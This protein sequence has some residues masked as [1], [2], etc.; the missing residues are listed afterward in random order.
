M[1]K[2]TEKKA[3]NNEDVREFIDAVKR[4]TASINEG[5][6]KT[7]ALAR[8][9]D[10][11][12]LEKPDDYHEKCKLIQGYYKKDD[13]FG[14]LVDS[15][16]EF[17]ANGHDW[18]VP[19][20]QRGDMKKGGEK[21][22]LEAERQEAVWRSWDRVIN[23]DINLMPGT[24]T[25]DDWIM[26]KA[27]LT[28]MCALT[29][30]YGMVKTNKADDRHRAYKMPRIMVNWPSESV[31]LVRPDNWEVPEKLYLKEPGTD[32]KTVTESTD[33]EEANT[34]DP[35]P[36]LSDYR[37]QKSIGDRDETYGSFVI[38]YKWS[39]ADVTI[40]DG[41]GEFDTYKGLYP[42]PPYE[43]L[44]PWLMMREAMCSSDLAILDG[45]INLLLVWWIGSEKYDPMAKT[46]A[47]DG[48]V[49]RESDFDLAKQLLE[50]QDVK[51]VMELFLPHYIKPEFITPPT[52]TMTDAEKYIQATKEMLQFFGIFEEDRTFFEQIIKSF[53]AKILVP[54]WSL[55]T[56]DIVDRNE[57]KLSEPPNRRYHPLPFN[58]DKTIVAVQQS[59]ERGEVSTETLHRVIGIDPTVERARVLKEFLRKDREVYNEM[60]PIQFSQDVVKDGETTTKE[61]SKKTG[62]KPGKKDENQRKSR[63]DPKKT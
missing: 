13:L 16:T 25:I 56:Q 36:D 33:I 62:R 18:E 44:L 35:N 28:G 10:M 17:A 61:T 59:H 24:G 19:I 4:I 63:D 20:D 53:R 38:K 37:E 21:K 15:V 46:L 3:K 49:E 47:V 30:K 41:E 57:K 39:P 22:L 5:R 14:R 29:W 58:S 12:K 7:L 43:K 11:P 26:T 9:K 40:I 55:L 51:K 60:V 2:K 45:L 34:A 48:T 42:D 27:Q 32:D 54:F 8:Y 52:E 23:K 1:T 6:G 50:N 31:L